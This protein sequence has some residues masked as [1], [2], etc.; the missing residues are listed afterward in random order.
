MNTTF[1]NQLEEK[2]EA[3]K[4]LDAIIVS[5]PNNESAW[6]QLSE[7]VDNLNEKVNCLEQ[8]LAINPNNI[9]AQYKLTKLKESIENIEEALKP[10]KTRE[11][12]PSQD[13]NDAG[14][15]LKEFFGSFLFEVIISII[16]SI[17]S[18]SNS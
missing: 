6:L 2:R 11:D 17:L 15:C 1:Q 18:P 9:A 5:E 7:V 14:S 8:A 3:R 12:D 10:V 16:L 4:R 13:A